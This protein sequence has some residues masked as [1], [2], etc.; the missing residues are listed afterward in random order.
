[1]VASR[2]SQ[3]LRSTAIGIAF[4]A[5]PC[6]AEALNLSEMPL[7]RAQQRLHVVLVGDSLTDSYP[8][9]GTYGTTLQH[10]LNQNTSTGAKV[11]VTVFGHRLATVGRR[12][13]ASFWSTPE[14]SYFLHGIHDVVVLMFGTN[15]ASWY[16]GC[17]MPCT[18]SVL[19]HR[20][21]MNDWRE[22]WRPMGLEGCRVSTNCSFVLD[23]SSLIDASLRT[24]KRM[25]APPPLIL[26]VT[27]PPVLFS[28]ATGI[29]GSLANSLLPELVER[30]AKANDLPPAIHLGHRSLLL[31]QPPALT[32]EVVN[33]GVHLDNM[34]PETLEKNCR[35]NL[36]NK[37]SHMTC[38]RLFADR[39]EPDALFIGDGIHLTAR[40]Y[41]MVAEHVN[42]AIRN[43]L[44]AR[45]ATQWWKLPVDK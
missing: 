1:M 2:S 7:T 14:Y 40:G 37:S 39:A 13:G 8:I 3:W 6:I 24:H 34:I 15:D 44:A 18:K 32:P 9:H 30:V 35:W 17:S 16:S 41:R 27:P 19:L 20:K 29:N 31:P 4:H 43:S 11:E 21:C 23:Y 38:D 25:N 36:L 10:L 28:C 22:E 42:V 33:A 5:T 45:N 12:S 26:L